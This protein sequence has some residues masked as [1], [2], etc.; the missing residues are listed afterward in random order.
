MATLL[1]FFQPNIFFLPYP[2]YFFQLLAFKPH[3]KGDPIYVFQE[4][5]LRGLV[6]NSTFKYIYVSDL[7]L[8]M[9]GPPILHDPGNI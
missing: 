7:Y 2:T 6:P 4:T 8:P 5:K 9:I 1:L 3:C